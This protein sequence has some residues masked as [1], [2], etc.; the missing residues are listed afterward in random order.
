MAR[1]ALVRRLFL[2]LPGAL[3]AL[4]AVVFFALGWSDLAALSLAAVAWFG[5]AAGWV[6]AGRARAAV[7]WV[8]AEV[9]VHPLVLQLAFGPAS[10]FGLYPVLLAA[11]APSLFPRGEP[12]SRLALGLLALGAAATHGLLAA[13]QPAQRSLPEGWL[14]GLGLMNGLT[15]VAVLLLFVWSAFAASERAEAR[16]EA[17]H[18]RAEGLLLDLLPAPIAARLSAG[19][20]SL[21]DGAEGVVVVFADLV[22]FTPLASQRSPAELVAL[23]DRFFSALD[24][25]TAQEGLEKIKTIG[26]AYL[27]VAGLPVAHPDGPAA[28]ARA[29]LGWQAAVARLSTELGLDLRLRVG[30]H[31]GPVV[32]G[33]IGRR[34]R[35]YDLWGDTVNV[36]SRLE[37]HGAPGRIQVSAEL[38][39][40]LGPR[41][42]VVERGPVELKGRGPV[43]AYW[44]EGASEAALGQ[45]GGLG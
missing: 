15:A 32:A 43:L 25:V 1:I 24:G 18:R 29:A 12:G 14:L 41:F 17:E 20:Q 4:Q 19:G 2:V 30:A 27:A 40:Q 10:G 23:L 39:R 3:H 9:L 7:W 8:A 26:D 22:G 36:A 44:L 6:R 42:R 11:A 35:V 28:A 38:A 37:S 34:R 33:V 5:G 16:A 31:L 13:T 21:A 45:E